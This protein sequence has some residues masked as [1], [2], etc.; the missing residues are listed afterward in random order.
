MRSI[1]DSTTYFLFCDGRVFER[2]RYNP[3]QPDLRV[4]IEGDW[5]VTT[6]ANDK[7]SSG[8]HCIISSV[9][10]RGEG[11]EITDSSSDGYT[12]WRRPARQGDA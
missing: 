9:P 1:K 8:A 5:E 12:K 3:W 7:F 4:E 11:W 6:T 2:R 10:P